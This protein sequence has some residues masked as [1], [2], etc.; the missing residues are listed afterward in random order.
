MQRQRTNSVPGYR[1]RQDLPV[2]IAM[3][4]AVCE[5]AKFTTYPDTG[6]CVEA[7]IFLGL[8]TKHPYTLELS[9]EQA[10]QAGIIEKV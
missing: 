1:V 3:F 7:S 2:P 10:L 6:P 5:E 8:L 4:G 9:F